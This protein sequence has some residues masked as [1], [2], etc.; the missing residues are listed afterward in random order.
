MTDWAATYAPLIGSKIEALK[1]RPLT[2]DTSTLVAD[3]QKPSFSYTGAVEIVFE[4]SRSLFITWQM[5]SGSCS[6]VAGMERSPEWGDHSLD[7]IRASAEDPW[8]SVDNAA[9]AGAS[10]YTLKEDCSPLGGYRRDASKHCLG[11]PVTAVRHAIHRD[12]ED[13]FFWLAI[14]NE[15]GVVDQDDLWVA[16][17]TAPPN[18]EDLVEIGS[19]G[20]VAAAAG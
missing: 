16:A 2:C 8:S 1:W 6:L 18:P 9:L 13:H 15:N 19:V 7:S 17:D 10:F 5:I 12:G 20:A 3:F 4:V 11:Y 14:G